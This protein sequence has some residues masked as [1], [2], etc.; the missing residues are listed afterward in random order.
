MLLV[1]VT[2]NASSAS[3]LLTARNINGV[4]F[5]GTGDITIV[6]PT[7]AGAGLT[8]GAYIQRDVQP[9]APAE[10]LGTYPETWNIKATSGNSG[11]FIVARD[12]S[13]N[14]SANT[15]TASLNG[16]AATATKWQ[17]SRSNYTNR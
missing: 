9:G 11:G 5:D 3:K 16:N 15:I 4:S 12:N 2:G 1:N 10:Y 13:G 6:A 14:F 7:G 8:A 17:T